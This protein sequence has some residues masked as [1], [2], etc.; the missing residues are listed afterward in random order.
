MG[1]RANGGVLGVVNT[2]TTNKASGL[3]SLAEVALYKK[4][5]TWPSIATFALSVDS[6]LV[7][8]GGSFTVTLTT[9]GVADGTL[10]PYTITGIASGDLSSGSLTGNFTVSSNTG[11]LTFTTASSGGTSGDLTATFSCGGDTETITIQE[12]DTYFKYVT[13]LLHGDGTNAANNNSFTDSS[14][15]NFTI[16]RNGDTTQG[17]F[18]PYG[19]T[20]SNYFDGVS[21]AYLTTPYSTT[22]FD[23]WTTDFTIEMWVYPTTF[24][25]WSYTDSSDV[26]P[27]LV[28]NNDS[29]GTTN[30]WCFGPHT[31]GV[32]HFVYWNGTASQ[33]KTGPT[34]IANQWNHIAMTKTSSGITL[35]ANGVGSTTTALVGTPQSSASYPLQVGRGNNTNISGY[36]GSLRIVKGTAVYS[37]STYTMPTAQL[38][39]ITNT[40]LLTCQSNR[41]VDIGPNAVA[42]TANGSPSVQKFSPFSP[43]AA[44]ST[45]GLGGSAY[46]DGAGDYLTAPSTSGQLGAGD[47]TVEAWIYPISRATTFP[48]IFNNY[49]S[50]GAGSLGIFAGHNSGNTS[51]YQV[52]IN[53]AAFP[54]IQSTDSIIYNQW[55]HIAVVR[56]S[57]VIT[58]YI[59][60]VANGTYTTSATLN[61]AGSSWIGTAGDDTANG[62]FNGYISGLRVVSGSAVYTTAFTPPTAPL[63]AITNTKLL[64]NMTNGGIIDNAMMNDWVTVGDVQVNT[65]TKKY[66]T[67]SMYF[68][69]NG[70]WLRVL[71]GPN[72][73]LQNTYTV[74]AWIYPVNTSAGYRT[75]FMIE[76]AAG[77]AFGAFSLYQSGTTLGFE[78]RPTSGGG[79]TTISGGTLTA[80]TWQHV[81]ISVSGTSGKLFLNGTQVG[82]TTTM[83][84]YSFSVSS[85]SVGG[86]PNGTTEGFNGYIDEF[87]VTKGYARY[88]S[89]FTAPTGPF[90]DR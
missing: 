62:I 42:I 16:T 86:H 3:W 20:W 46:F 49:S 2:P 29:A 34:L 21:P 30:Y 85:C 5:G 52:S 17:T 57:G 56:S 35:F 15:N 7:N 88:T 70:D 87:R 48:T 71:Y 28:G 68:D 45:S 8:K 82:S 53:G 73:A 80:N 59:N 40:K 61:G 44:Y 9:T 90:Q 72:M 33:A 67:G 81:A 55:T 84:D 78:V 47:F 66:G 6:A 37:G 79:V 43:T 77:A 58:L 65:T 83:P 51:K 19:D 31:N 23:W 69:G 32:L 24:A 13:A 41:F 18:T 25:N 38:T 12:G 4:A 63:T 76:A 60:G 89:N 1:K 64:L 39:A 54:V 11:S 50:Y 22:N 14:S 27:V 74:E 75:M 10:V 26:K 36:V